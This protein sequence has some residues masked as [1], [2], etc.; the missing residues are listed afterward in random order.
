MLA[1]PKFCHFQWNQWPGHETILSLKSSS[2]YHFGSDAPLF[3]F[4]PMPMNHDCECM[5]VNT[6]MPEKSIACIPR[7]Y[8][9]CKLSTVN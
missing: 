4:F 9:I 6:R 7:A 2:S 1:E 5:S 8:L 3:F